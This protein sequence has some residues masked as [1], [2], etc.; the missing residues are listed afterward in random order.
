MDTTRREFLRFV[1]GA[2]VAVAIGPTGR[3]AGAAEPQPAPA[4]A[5]PE[6]E[7][8]K[9][10]IVLFGGGTRSSEA[11]ADPEH[12]YI[13]HLWNELVPRGTLFSNMRVEHLVVHPNCNAAIKTGH[14]EWDDLDWSKPPQHPTIFEIF[15]KHRAAPDTAAWSFVYASILALTGESADAGY[16]SRYAANVAEPPTIPRTTAEDMERRMRH[17]AATGSLEAERT[18][19]A[20]CARLV[21]ENSHVDTAGLRSPEARTWFDERFQA[22]QSA[23]G[24][25]SH[26]AFLADCAISCMEKFSPGVMSVDFGEID[27][28]HYGS[29]SRYVEAIRRTDELT[30]RLWQAVEKM[31]D[32]RGKTLMLVLPDHGRE[33][34]RPGGSG[35]VHHSDFYRDEGADEGCRRVWM[36]ALGPGVP[37]GQTIERATPITAVAAT[38]LT[39]LGLP[40]PEGLA[41]T[42]LGFA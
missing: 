42:A 38:A 18:A 28:A 2:G 9:A 3:N 12:R 22:W 13:P 21:R 31:P 5:R 39:Y 19:A 16:G 8:R 6:V 26:D 32:Y 35:F 29:W 15:R 41:E 10:I 33:L 17:A 34:E 1:T 11:V 14:W 25:T 7:K 37:A 30:A 23:E 20:E 36:L 40:V 4:A 24:S 27:C